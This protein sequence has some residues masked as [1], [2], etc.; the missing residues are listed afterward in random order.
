VEVEQVVGVFQDVL[1][2]GGGDL[3][4]Q[5]GVLRGRD[6]E[7]AVRVGVVAVVVEVALQRTER[8]LVRDGHHEQ[9]AAN[10]GGAQPRSE[11][12]EG[13]EVVPLVAVQAGEQRQGGTVGVAVEDV[14]GQPDLHA[15]QVRGDGD[16][17]PMPAW[18]GRDLADVSV[19][20]H[21]ASLRQ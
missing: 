9:L 11:F 6:R 8:H 20:V 14:D 1:G 10:V 12:A 19:N 4:G 13:V 16:A 15:V 2:H 21:S 18:L 17:D 7:G 5:P 3:L